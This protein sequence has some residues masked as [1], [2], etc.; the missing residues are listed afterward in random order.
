LACDCGNTRIKLGHVKGET[1]AGARSYRMGDL[2]E[3]GP[4]LANLWASMPEPKRIVAASV[5][6]AALHALEA[7]ALEYI[8]QEVAVVGRDLDLPMPIRLAHPEKVGTDRLC[9]AVAAYDQLGAACV[10]ADAGTALTIDC[11][12]DEGEFLG[13]AILPGLHM[14]AAALHEHTAQLPAVELVDPDW[15]FGGN[16]KQTIIGGIVYGMRGALKELTE[17]YATELGRW[18]LLILTGGDAKHLCPDVQENG[19]VQ[20]IVEDLSLR[21]I[22]IAYYKSVV[23]RM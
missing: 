1:V 9:V 5:N 3:L 19:L 4:A 14:Q 7:A 20:A 8:Q 18:P 16:T 12:N 6:T 23:E 11:V 10:V 13:G 22:A 15:V 17:A 2:G 21:G